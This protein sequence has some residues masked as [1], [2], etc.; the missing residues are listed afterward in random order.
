MTS[1]D[2]RLAQKYAA[3][4]KTSA[5]DAKTAKETARRERQESR[6]ARRAP[7]PVAEDPME[8]MRR[9][10]A[11]P[12]TEESRQRARAHQRSLPRLGG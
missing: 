4:G 6:A 9:A 11:A 1:R 5:T 10:I 2:Q 7:A 12:R 3:Q 8:A